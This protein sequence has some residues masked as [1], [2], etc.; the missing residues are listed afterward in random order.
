MIDLYRAAT[1]NGHNFSTALGGLG[2]PGLLLPV[3]KAAVP[4]RMRPTHM[5]L[6]G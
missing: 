5:L 6:Q 2:L 1:A 3:R 4:Q